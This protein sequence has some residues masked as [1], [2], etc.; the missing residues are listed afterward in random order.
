[1]IHVFNVDELPNVHIFFPLKTETINPSDVQKPTSISV[2]VQLSENCLVFD[3]ISELWSHIANLD[4]YNE[5]RMKSDIS[6][7][8]FW[9]KVSRWSNQLNFHIGDKKKYIT[10]VSS[11]LNGKYIQD[12]VFDFQMVPGFPVN[13]F[14][15]VFNDSHINDKGTGILDGAFVIVKYKGGFGLTIS[16]FYRSNCILVNMI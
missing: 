12:S 4:Y 3:T 8:D 5:K 10:V 6:V 11:V 9:N 16:E 2:A 1:M 14:L 15:I 7:L 13:K